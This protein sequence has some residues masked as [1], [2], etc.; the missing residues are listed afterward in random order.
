[1]I[2]YLGACILLCAVSCQNLRDPRVSIAQGTVIG[3]YNTFY[4]FYGIPYGDT[5]SGTNRFKAPK[6]APLFDSPFKANRKDISCLRPMRNG[7]KGVEDCLSLN[8]VTPK[9][10]ST[11]RL[12]VL[13]W[14]KD[15]EFD[16]HEP[17]LSYY[18][19]FVEK[20]VIVVT[21][22]FRESLLGFLC[23]GTSSAPGNA[24]LKDIIAALKWIKL[25][26]AAFGGDPENVTVFGH[27]SGAAMVD[28]LTLSNM[29]KG[30][31]QKAIFQSKNDVESW[32]VTRDNSKYAIV[33]AKALGHTVEDLEAL[34]H[35]FTRIS[36]PVLMA[37]VHELELTENSLAFAPCMERYLDSRDVEPFIL[38]SPFENVGEKIDIPFMT[39]FINGDR[40][41]NN[42]NEKIVTNNWN[43][44]TT[45]IVYTFILIALLSIVRNLEISEIM[46]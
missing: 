16:P 32:A 30:L 14:I 35:I 6:P 29:S 24:G 18:K 34:S 45:L 3:S 27:G 1:M 15:K 26:I 33:I 11:L 12:N 8:I 42:T 20:D 17:E 43:C 10:N 44:T 9:L 4:E 37:V 22:N 25:N 31:F 41:K 38:K 46:L 2:W 28:L 13:V 7:Y 5:T 19:H 40:I 39:G 21:P 36:A 23:L